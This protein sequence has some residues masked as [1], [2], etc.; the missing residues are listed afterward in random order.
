MMSFSLPRRDWELLSAYIDGD[1][2]KRA[3]RALQTRLAA[4]A[5][6]RLALARLQRTRALLRRAPRCRA[7]RSFILRPEM[8]AA[9]PGWRWPFSLSAASAVATIMLALVLLGD[10]ALYGIPRIPSFGAAAPAAEIAEE[11]M[12]LKAPTVADGGAE[13]QESAEST[14]PGEADEELQLFAAQEEA[15]DLA[16]E[17]SSEMRADES[18]FQ[19]FLHWAE[20]GL[21]LVALFSGLEHWRRKKT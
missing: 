19:T 10:F 17:A 14:P 7:P 1:L 21:A 15:E 9:K 2:D 8:V 11:P 3:T 6:L 12:A 5:D 16:L 13:A 18:G 4:D 20:L